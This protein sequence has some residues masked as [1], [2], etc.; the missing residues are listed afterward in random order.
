MI[1]IFLLDFGGPEKQED[2]RPFLE[3]LF[4]DRDIFPM[5]AGQTLFAKIAARLRAPK[6]EK[7]YAKMGGGSPLNRQSREIAAQ[8]QENLRRAN[9]D[10]RVFTGFRYW[11]P[12][13]SETLQE[14]EG[15]NPQGIIVIPMFPQYSTATT[16]SV[17]KQFK[18]A[19][20]TIYPTQPPLTKGRSVPFQ[21]VEWWYD[22]PQFVVGWCYS[23]K[24]ALD[25]FDPKIR[26]TVPV[27]FSAHGLPLSFI[28][29]RKDPY[30]KQIQ[31]CAGSIMS[32]FGGNNP[33]YISY[34][35]KVGP[36]EWLKPATIEFVPK[37]ALEGV[38]NLVIA[39]ISFITDHLE[40]LYEIDHEIIPAGLKNGMEKIVRCEALVHTPYL[41]K[42][43]ED[44]ALK[45]IRTFLI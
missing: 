44:L 3:N 31:E 43:L 20:S 39:P 27:L 17:F 10:I 37:L 15:Q 4:S 35:S 9:L 28:T 2:V 6:V 42:T 23:I 1:S 29:E 45:R 5:P 25:Q 30:P 11:G 33:A 16:L 32:Y 24:K 13:I 38:Q 40:T 34:Q 36:M 14:I 8:L 41:L 12:S 18:E 21:F 22:Q 26:D 7:Q 19:M